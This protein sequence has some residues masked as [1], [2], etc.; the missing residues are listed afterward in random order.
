MDL[1]GGCKAF[2]AVS[3]AGSFTRGAALARIPQSVASRRISALERHLGERLFD[4]SSRRAILTPF[5]RDML[6]SAQRL[7]RLADAIEQD[8]QRAKSRP[9]RIAVPET[10]TTRGL[11]ELD[12]EARAHELFLEFH[13][14]TPGERAE[15]VRTHD[16][17]AAITAVPAD[18]GTWTV[19]LG[20]AGTAAM[21]P[22]AVHLETLRVGRS[23]RLPRRRVW[24][25]PEDDVPHIRDRLMRIRDAVGL[26][27]AQV[28][29]AESLT[30]AIADVLG[31]ADLLVCS[32]AQ[33]CELGMAWRS[34]GEG[35]LERGFD[36]TAA[37]AGDA[38]RIRNRLSNAVA[39]S[40][41]ATVDGQETG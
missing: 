23:R 28:A 6:P 7:V 3:E 22:R 35:R 1:V 14:A 18:A 2:V 15:L 41:G 40:L 8:A 34:I 5:G 4:R 37:V 38:E 32:A 27:P 31:S 13:P 25:Q 19:P 17:R 12:S 11:A 24:I 26:H 20:L 21:P 16:V 33:A 10:C 30:A 36:I 39:R 29:V 9:L